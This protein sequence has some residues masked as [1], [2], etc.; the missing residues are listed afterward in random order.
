MIVTRQQ[1][2]YIIAAI[3]MVKVRLVAVVIIEIIN[4]VMVVN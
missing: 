3:M 1:D 4:V 2:I